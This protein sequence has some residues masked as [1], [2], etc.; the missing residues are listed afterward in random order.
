MSKQAE[1]SLGFDLPQRSESSLTDSAHEKDDTRTY[2]E[3]LLEQLRDIGR[4]Q[5]KKVLGS[6]GFGA[7]FQA[8]DPI[9][10]RDV[11]IKVPLP[12]AS[13]QS[14]DEYLAEARNV[15]RLKHPGIV[16]V[17]DAG[18][19]DH[20]L[21]Y[22]VSAFIPGGD[23]R[24]IRTFTHQEA[25][26]LVAAVAD[27]FHHAHTR[28]LVHRDIKPA[29][30]LIDVDGKPYVADFGIALRVQDRGHGPRFIGTVHYMSPEQSRREGDRVDGRSDIF[31]LGVVMYEL[32]TGQRPFV[33]DSLEEIRTQVETFEPRPLRQIDDNIPPD[34]ERICARA[35]AKRLRGRYPTAKDMAVEL[36]QF[37]ARSEQR[38]ARIAEGAG[39]SEIREPTR[40]TATAANDRRWPVDS[41]D[42]AASLRGYSFKRTLAKEYGLSVYLAEAS[43]TGNLVEI[44][45]ADKLA[46]RIEQD[47]HNYVS[48]ALQVCRLTHAGIVRVY[49]VIHD[50]DICFVVQDHAGGT[51][52]AELTYEIVGQ[53]LSM[54]P[55]KFRSWPESPIRSALRMSTESYWAISILNTSSSTRST[56]SHRFIQVVDATSIYGNSDLRGPRATRPHLQQARRSYRCV[57]TWS[58]CVRVARWHTTIHGGTQFDGGDH[59]LRLLPVHQFDSSIPQELETVCLK[60]LEKSPS[61]RYS[62]AP[63]LGRRPEAMGRERVAIHGDFSNS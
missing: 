8:Y 47:Y 43:L 30:I 37:L 46:F 42:R 44:V 51:T 4:Y 18:R 58:Y 32:L 35:L 5:L 24:I 39:T 22:V 12:T 16:E 26:Q 59:G 62:T 55:R 14:V 6:G 27:A 29:N 54:S 63:R 20:G 50:D 28:G 49:E 36:R 48:A 1:E 25:A 3:T 7:V 13:P 2:L 11:A 53:D 23:L 34:L 60:C 9:I 38:A 19:T 31:S 10:D 56:A 17:Y 45:A 57:A 52:L 40:G 21:C 41:R 61:N 15:G 33:G